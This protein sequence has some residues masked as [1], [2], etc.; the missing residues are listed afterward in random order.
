MNSPSQL[1]GWTSSGGDPCG[2]SWKGISCSGSK[3][4]EMYLH[5][6]LLALFSAEFVV[7]MLH[8]TYIIKLLRVHPQKLPTLPDLGYVWN[9]SNLSG[10]GLTGSIG[11]K[12]SDLKSVTRFDL[13]KNSFKGNIPYQ[14]P[15]NLQLID[16]SGNE[17]DGN[18]PYSISQMTD[19]KEMN[20]ENN[21]F[22]GW[23]PNELKDIKK[24]KYLHEVCLPSCVHMSITSSNILLDAELNPRLSDCGLALLY[25]RRNQKLETGYSA[26][27]STEVCADPL[28][29]DV[30]SFGVVML[31]LMT[32]RMPFDS[33]KPKYEQSLVRWASPQLHDLD[34]LG[35]MA[36][37]ALHGLYPPKSL[38][39]FADVIALCVQS[40]PEFRP[41][42][43]QVVQALV[44]LGQMNQRGMDF[45]TSRRID[46]DDDYDY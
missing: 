33:R 35:R 8:I 45:S 18:V 25:E 46:D 15:P 43:S 17:F 21:K 9:G 30:Y 7:H 28:K 36:D 26:P 10:L 2:D 16:L 41:P 13:S 27:E 11:Y 39:G 14:L 42:I 6:L 38:S 44:R 3:V 1:D 20:V 32:G 22:T 19:L 4:T 40:E 34:A 12:L 24:I 5:T 31:E 37:P 23:I 29:G